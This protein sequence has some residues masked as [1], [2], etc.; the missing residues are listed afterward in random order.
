MQG[1]VIFDM[2]T[3]IRSSSKLAALDIVEPQ[4]RHLGITALTVQTPT[5]S[6]FARVDGARPKARWKTPEFTFYAIVFILVVPLMAWTPYTLSR[7]E[8][9]SYISEVTC[10]LA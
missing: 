1:D 3:D 10:C 4:G 5:S 9:Q 8:L 7:R 6:R 2:P